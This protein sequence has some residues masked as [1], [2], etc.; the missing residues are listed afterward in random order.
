LGRLHACDE[1]FAL[2]LDRA[3]LLATG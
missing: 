2:F 1:A 3:A